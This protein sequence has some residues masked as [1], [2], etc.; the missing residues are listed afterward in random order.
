MRDDAFAALGRLR[1]ESAAITAS[2]V[3]SL[4]GRQAY[5]AGALHDCALKALAGVE[6]ALKH[7]Q[8]VPLYGS[9]STEEEPG[10]CPHDPDSFLHF[11]ADDGSGEWLCEGKT[12]GAACSCTES[13]D[14]EQ[15]PYPCDE[16]TAILAALTL[17]SSPAAKTGDSNYTPEEASR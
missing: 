6:A 2:L 8:R 5:A 10:A 1:E 15:L 14:G 7:H 12:E 9:A 11:E 13:A 3:P 16:V 17:T 4:D